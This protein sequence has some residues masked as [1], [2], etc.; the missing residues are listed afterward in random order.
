ME[1]P[2]GT[3]A[4]ASYAAYAAAATIFI[5]PS[6]PNTGAIVS[7]NNYRYNFGGSTPYGGWATTGST[8]KSSD[9]G[10]ASSPWVK[11]YAPKMYRPDF[12]RLYSSREPQQRKPEHGRQSARRRLLTWPAISTVLR[13]FSMDPNKDDSNDM[14]T[15]ASTYNAHAQFV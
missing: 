6:D 15:Y 3:V 13:C 1:N 8:T 11:R 12:R 7:E 2:K 9:N 4:N 5:C 14:M 10:T